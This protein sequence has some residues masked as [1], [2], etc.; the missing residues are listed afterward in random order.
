MSLP[1]PAPQ[2]GKQLRKMNLF[3]NTWDMRSYIFTTNVGTRPLKRSRGVNH[4]LLI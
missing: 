4:P 2:I 3:S 1:P